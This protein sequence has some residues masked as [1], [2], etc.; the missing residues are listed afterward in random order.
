MSRPRIVALVPMRH[1]SERVPR[2]NYR[3]IAGRP[4]YAHILTTL[5]ACP[6][7]DEVVVDTDSPLVLHDCARLFPTVRLIERPEALRD[8]MVPMN[9]V[10]LHTTSLVEAGYFLQTHTTN[11]LLKPETISRAIATFFDARPKYDSLFGVTAL[12][13]RLWWGDGTAVNHDP[14]VLLRTQDLPP[15]YE[16]NSNLYIFDRQT[17]V[18]RQNRIGERPLLFPIPRDEAWD[19]DEETDFLIAEQLLELARRTRAA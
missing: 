4:L 18:R 12:Q 10:L 11:P 7:V 5:L 15:V 14:A 9:D 16:E 8:G 13:T 1:S 17:L 2:K 19:I 3:M 6:E